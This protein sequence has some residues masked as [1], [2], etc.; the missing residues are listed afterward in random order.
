MFSEQARPGLGMLM[1]NHLWE[2]RQGLSKQ[3]LMFAYMTTDGNSFL[4]CGP[5][6]MPADWV[7]TPTFQEKL[8]GEGMP[9]KGI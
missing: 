6:N 7:I 2:R 3:G 4:L 8:P 5:L 9:L 1:V